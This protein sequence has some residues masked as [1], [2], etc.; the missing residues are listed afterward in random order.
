MEK[1]GNIFQYYKENISG[2]MYFW[3]VKINLKF[4]RVKGSHESEM[5]GKSKD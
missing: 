4:K 5:G 3:S 2:R 1:A